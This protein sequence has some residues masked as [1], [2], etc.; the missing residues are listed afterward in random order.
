[1]DVQH[2]QHPDHGAFYVELD[3][4]RAG[5]MTYRRAGDTITILHTEVSDRLRGQGAGRQLLDALVGWV[6]EAHAKVVP[7]C[8]F[9][10]ATFEKT[11]ALQ[12]VLAK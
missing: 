10:K 8:P 6:R 11:P 5:E 3:G 7:V 12:D 4:A 1:M 2:E 9:A